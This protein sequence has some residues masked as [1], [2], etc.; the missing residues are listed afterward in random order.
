M[1]QS[2]MAIGLNSIT[3]LIKALLGKLLLV[4]S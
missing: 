3:L 4:K 1:P 2:I